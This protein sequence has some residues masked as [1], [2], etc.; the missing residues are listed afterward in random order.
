MNSTV[1][2]EP[3]HFDELKARYLLDIKAAAQ[4]AKILM[5]LIMNWD[6]TGVNIVPGSHWTLEGKGAKRV[7]CTGVDDK[8]Q[9]TVVICATASGIFSYHFK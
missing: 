1:K 8:H 3:S 7:E 2:V 5:D 9:I 6:H 4:I